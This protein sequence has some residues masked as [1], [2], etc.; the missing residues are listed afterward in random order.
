MKGKDSDG[1]SKKK[2]RQK[3]DEQGDLPSK[4]EGG[5]GWWRLGAGLDGEI[6]DYYRSLNELIGPEGTLYD[7]EE[8]ATL[9]NNAL[10]EAVGKEAM[11]A[12]HSDCSHVLEVLLKE[13]DSQHLLA[14]FAGCAPRW[15]SVMCGP[16]GSHVA[17]LLLQRAVDMLL[18]PDA[19]GGETGSGDGA[20]SED[21]IQ[22]HI[23]SAVE[24]LCEDVLGIV[25]D[26]YGSHVFRRQLALFSGEDIDAAMGSGV[27]GTLSQKVRGGGQAAN[28]R[29]P[30]WQA[31]NA[32][33]ASNSFLRKQLA[34]LSTAMLAAWQGLGARED[35]E[36]LWLNASASAALQALLYALKGLHADIVTRSALGLLEVDPAAAEC[37]E[38]GSLEDTLR[39]C[40]PSVSPL[41]EERCASHLMEAILR[42]APP[43]LLEAAFEV[44]F[45]GRLLELAT[46]PI[47]N[48]VVQAMVSCIAQGA[49]LVAVLEELMEHFGALLE[50]RR[51]GVILAL[52]AACRRL[53]AHCKP[54]AKALAKA[55]R[56]VGMRAS[57]SRGDASSGNSWQTAHHLVSSLAYLDQPASW[58]T[59]GA[60]MS[61]ER[62]SVLGCGILAQVLAFPQED[63]QQFVVAL[64]RLPKED[65]VRMATDGGGSRVVEAFLDSAAEP[66]LKKKFIKNLTNH[67]VELGRTAPGSWCVEKCY[68]WADVSLKEAITAE[69]AKGERRVAPRRRRKRSGR[70]S[71][72]QVWWMWGEAAMGM[73]LRMPVQ[74][75]RARTRMP[76]EVAARRE[77]Q[78]RARPLWT[79]K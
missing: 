1:Q 26:R 43:D 29:R 67:F 66:A 27:G 15:R 6:S 65:C 2:R 35:R 3:K 32:L 12:D 39:R 70:R 79:R 76:A 72:I 60:P 57:A 18:R 69:L 44:L 20:L 64:S 78:A 25:S 59:P 30:S 63:C 46:H 9:C 28:G 55:L 58:R 47:A 48:F 50:A 4:A 56:D 16:C 42:V 21:S 68:V 54:A 31:A 34:R 38:P 41:M 75:A 52:L 7:A 51:A 13:A 36:Y 19:R 33:A 24:A 5:G 37:D 74:V 61:H 8:R 77:R 62:L 17:E 49:L 53:R 45:R 22:Q 23:S 11:I 40:A 10:E 71:W 73:E 14:F